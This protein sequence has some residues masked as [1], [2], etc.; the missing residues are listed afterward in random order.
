MTTRN[1]ALSILDLAPVIEGG[2]P[3]DSFRDT[4]DLAQHAEQW[5]YHRYWLTEHHNMQAVASAATSVI[6]GHVAAH[7]DKIRVGSGGIMLANHA[8]LMIAE[9]FGTLESLYPG[10]IDLGLGRA[11]GTDQPAMRALRRGLHST[12]EDFPEQLNELRSYLN[13]ALNGAVP[14]VRAIPGE[15]LDIPIWLLGSSGFSAQLAGQ[16]G[17]P[18]AFASHFAPAHLLQALELYHR[19]FRPSKALDKPYVMVGVNVLVADS[20]EEAKWLFTSQEQQFLN[21]LRGHSGGLKPP[22]DDMEKLW[23]EHEKEMVRGN[24][25]GYSAI[26]SPDTVK[27]KMDLIIDQTRANELI[28]T[29]QVYDHQARLRSYELLA[30]VM[31]IVG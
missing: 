24:M 31:R 17:L 21:V 29:S 23:S 30:K 14:G 20:D 25:L 9:Q 2:T 8:P 15:G 10:R 22:V 18:F 19:N 11:P 1:V 16:L 5:G 12:G 13:P 3:A 28:T 26:G 6:I 27:Q 7:T 4:V